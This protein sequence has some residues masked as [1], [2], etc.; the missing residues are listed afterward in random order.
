MTFELHM[1]NFHFT[2][3]SAHHTFIEQQIYKQMPAEQK[4][5]K[6]LFS[7]AEHFEIVKETNKQKKE[8]KAVGS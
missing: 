1:Q 2:N 7:P 5:K 6:I 3:E 4:N 8:E